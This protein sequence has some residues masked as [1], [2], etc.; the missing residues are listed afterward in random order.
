[1][2]PSTMG[3][4]EERMNMQE[5]NYMGM[6]QKVRMNRKGKMVTKGGKSL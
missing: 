4:G 1:M 3:R 5:G 6:S 2:A